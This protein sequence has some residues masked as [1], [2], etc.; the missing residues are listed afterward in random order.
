MTVEE[1][2][3]RL[4]VIRQDG[5]DRRQVQRRLKQYGPNRLRETGKKSVLQL[6]INQLKSLIVALL[7]VAAVLSFVFD[8]RINGIAISGVIVVNTLIGF[9]MEL[10][11]IRSME[12]L[13]QMERV[14][15]KVRRS[16][17]VIEISARQLVPGDIVVLEGGD[18][19]SA[20]M[21]LVSAAKV[22]AN[23]SVLTGE[24]LPVG[25]QVEPVDEAS[26]LGDRLSMLFKG[27]AVTRG[28][29]EA[30][31]VATGMNTELGGISDLIQE[32]KEETT[33]LEKQLDHLGRKLLWVTLI[34]IAIIA[35][36]GIARGKEVLLMIETAIALAVAAIP[37]GL[38]IVATLALARG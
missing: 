2:V 1:T 18:I 36:A 20:D 24:S 23:E 3:K 38:P 14:S 32:A 33:P 10:K 35:G 31:V 37:E 12:A 7:A 4:Q 15:A 26:V 27:T 19:I 5:L 9:F 22:Q 25:K 28:S 11:A 8:E 29:A 21:R 16:G 6:F 34:L 13:Q 17:K 30:V